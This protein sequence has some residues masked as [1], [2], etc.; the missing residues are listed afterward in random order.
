MS[1]PKAIKILL[2]DGS[3]EGVRL[4]EIG[5]WTGKILVIP[6][7]LVNEVIELRSSELATPAL[8]FLKGKSKSFGQAIYVGESE[9]IARRLRQ[10]ASK[11][12]WSESIFVM[13]KDRNLHKG[14]LKYLEF[15][16]YK[17][18]KM[19]ATAHLM[20]AT[21]PKKPNLSEID[22]SEMLHFM[23]NVKLALEAAGY[24]FLRRPGKRAPHPA[25]KDSYYTSFSESFLQ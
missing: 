10:H 2:P 1:R 22:Q 14:H 24:N 17:L 12:F 18:L 19:S 16:A 4:I 11:R 21:Q 6:R 8:Y 5:N 23:F 9:N 7:S 15:A 25:T 3:L 20:N 13:A